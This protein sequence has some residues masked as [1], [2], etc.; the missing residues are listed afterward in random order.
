MHAIQFDQFLIYDKD[1]R[2]AFSSRRS[3]ISSIKI[4]IKCIRCGHLVFILY[5]PYRWICSTS[6]CIFSFYD[7]LLPLWWY[8]LPMHI[9]LF[10]S[11]SIDKYVLPDIRKNKN[12]WVTNGLKITGEIH[13]NE[14]VLINVLPNGART[15]SHQC[16]PKLYSSFSNRILAMKPVNFHF[17][18]R[19][20]KLKRTRCVEFTRSFLSWNEGTKMLSIFSQNLYLNSMNRL[21]FDCTFWAAKERKKKKKCER[22][23]SHQKYNILMKCETVMCIACIFRSPRKFEI[24][25]T[26]WSWINGSKL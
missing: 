25:N 18:K 19:R 1:S 22:T 7:F 8:K 6:K 24:N 17:P 16:I 10:L 3:P 5:I 21:H 15:D 11:S 2:F 9:L 4:F 20:S 26:Q 14:A 23:K 12:R 13:F